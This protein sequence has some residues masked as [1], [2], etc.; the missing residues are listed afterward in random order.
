MNFPTIFRIFAF[1]N[2]KQKN[3]KNFESFFA[4]Y[5]YK[6][7]CFR[8]RSCSALSSTGCCFL[9]A[10]TTKEHIN[11]IYWFPVFKIMSRPSAWGKSYFVVYMMYFKYRYDT[12]KK[13][14][15]SKLWMQY[16]KSIYS[17]H[18]K[19]LILICL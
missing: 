6:Q 18:V 4:H 7:R 15:N 14:S 2:L 19:K 10:L 11:M 13:V 3:I 9:H 12:N 16:T 17:T 5:A 1:L 8:L